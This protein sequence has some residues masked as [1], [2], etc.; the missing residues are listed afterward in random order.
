MD[1][2]LPE[3]NM[4]RELENKMNNEIN[5]PQGNGEGYVIPGANKRIKRAPGDL[6]MT[7]EQV[8]EIGKGKHKVYVKTPNTNPQVGEPGSNKEDTKIGSKTLAGSGEP[9]TDQIASS[10]ESTQKG[11]RNVDLVEKEREEHYRKGG[12][13]RSFPSR[14]KR[15]VATGLFV[16][17]TGVGAAWG[18]NQIDHYQAGQTNAQTVGPDNIGQDKTGSTPKVRLPG[19]IEPNRYQR[20]QMALEELSQINHPDALERTVK[21]N[22]LEQTRVALSRG[23]QTVRDFI[24]LRSRD[25]RTPENTVNQETKISI[26][27]IYVADIIPGSAPNVLP[28]DTLENPLLN[29]AK[30]SINQ[31]LTQATFL[32]EHSNDEGLKGITQVDVIISGKE[33]KDKL[34]TP[35]PLLSGQSR[36]VLLAAAGY[37]IY[38]DGKGPWSYNNADMLKAAG[39]EFSD[40]KV[41][42]LRVYPSGDEL[43]LMD[44]ITGKIYGRGIRG[45]R[46]G[47]ID[48]KAEGNVTQPDA[49][50]NPEIVTTTPTKLSQEFLQK[51]NM[52]DGMR[53]RPIGAKA[54]WIVETD[55]PGLNIQ[56]I[57]LDDMKIRIER[58]AAQDGLDSPKRQVFKF[59]SQTDGKLIDGSVLRMSGPGGIGLYRQVVITDK[60]P[61]ETVFNIYINP[62]KL[63][64]VKKIKSAEGKV[65]YPNVV[66]NNWLYIALAV[67]YGGLGPL[68]DKT[69]VDEIVGKK[70]FTPEEIKT[71][72][73]AKPENASISVT[74]QP[75]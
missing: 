46:A 64:E 7:P 42:T 47:I 61:N 50:I 62:A 10:M 26:S 48:W 51:E 5:N 30:D 72:S 15:A 65:L 17:A 55:I 25:G 18:K 32:I 12:K 52:L 20:T 40:P 35:V 67:K 34:V 33:N 43:L 27:K 56:S 14:A 54:D 11:H 44:R 74:Y 37:G 53:F 39:L 23:V 63:D 45:D 21:R 71:G 58:D 69:N 41:S 19:P 6:N 28:Y 68:A 38:W 59:I 4:T 73:W 60:D 29:E 3:Q 8:L 49:N 36:G 24:P 9:S 70:I 57:G 31:A 1:V 75:R 13:P 16:V 66:I 22:L 2:K